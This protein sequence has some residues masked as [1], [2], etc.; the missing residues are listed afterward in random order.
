M[1]LMLRRLQSVSGLHHRDIQRLLCHTVWHN[2][3]DIYHAS[4]LVALSYIALYQFLGWIVCCLKYMF[5]IF[6]FIKKIKSESLLIMVNCKIHN[7]TVDT[8]DSQIPHHMGW[9]K[10]A[11]IPYLM[12]REKKFMNS[13]AMIWYAFDM[14]CHSQASLI[15]WCYDMEMLF[16]LLTLCEGNS[17]VIEWFLY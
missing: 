16:T 3:W 17:L 13:M 7:H 4:G 9:K 12:G 14:R 11:Q 5:T 1:F 15:W 2:R 6:D 10:Y 8:A